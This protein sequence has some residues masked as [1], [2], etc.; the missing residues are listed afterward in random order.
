M[1]R[2]E[3]KEVKNS[4]YRMIRGESLII[5]GR[6]KIKLQHIFLNQILILNGRDC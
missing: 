3:V 5:Q 2:L 6:K 4:P 1:V